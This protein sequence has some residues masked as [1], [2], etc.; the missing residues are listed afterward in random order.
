MRTLKIFLLVL[1]LQIT[2]SAQDTGW[3]WQNPLPT[4]TQLNEIFFTNSN[5]A[6]A[7]GRS[8][9]IIKTTD[10]GDNWVFQLSGTMNHLNGIF[11]VNAS[12]GVTV[13]SSGTI[14]KTT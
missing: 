1:I 9:T 10:C 14:I 11:F 4:G 7:V 13:G 12:I 2:I 3:F 8:G 6:I 5:T